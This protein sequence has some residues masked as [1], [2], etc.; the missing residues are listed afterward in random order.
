MYTLY[1]QKRKQYPLVE[2]YTEKSFRQY[3]KPGI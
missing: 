1:V 3:Q 2:I